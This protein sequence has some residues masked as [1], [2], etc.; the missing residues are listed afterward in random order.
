VP[1][2]GLGYIYFTAGDSNGSTIINYKYNINGGSYNLL[3]PADTNSPILIPSLSNGFT[4]TI[5]LIAINGVGD[6]IASDSISIAPVASSVPSS[7]LYYDPSDPA[8]YPGNGTTINNIGSY[9]TLNGTMTNVTY[10]STIANGIFDFNG[11]SSHIAFGN[12]NFGNSFTV[13]AWVFPRQTSNING[14]LANIGSNQS[15]A[16]FKLAWNWWLTNSR[17]IY[18]EGGNGTSG[19]ANITIIDVINYNTWQHLAYVFD[20]TNRQII[21]FLNGLPV[22]MG[23][24]ISTVADIDTDNVAFRIGS[25]TD[26]FYRM[27]ARLG[28]LKMFNSELS[29]GDIL[30]DYNTTRSRFGL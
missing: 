12:F 16:G 23:S 9:G 26:G 19:G 20:K 15:P 29:A 11:T 3:S 6:S 25:F 24:S 21:F 18:F 1:G 27:N 10:D 8:S 2:D 30:A 28:Y 7:Y 13:T 17:A 4:Y 14:L 5:T 22:D